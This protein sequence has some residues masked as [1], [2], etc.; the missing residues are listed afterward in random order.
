MNKTILFLKTMLVRMAGSRSCPIHSVKVWHKHFKSLKMD[1]KYATLD[2]FLNNPGLQHLAREIFLNINSVNSLQACQ[3]I[4]QS[5]KQIFETPL[6]WLKKFVQRGL[7][8]KNQEDWMK[9]I[10]SA[11]NSDK[12]NHL[13]LFFKWTFQTK[14]MVDLPCYTNPIVQ[15][16]FRNQIFQSARDNNLEIVKI[17]APLTDNPNAPVKHGWTPIMQAAYHG[18][19][20]IVKIL[21]PL[22]D[23]P[24]TPDKD[25]KTP[26]HLAVCMEA[27]TRGIQKLSNY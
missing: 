8:K 27:I 14:R 1:N 15:D 10:Q 4:N 16:D 6:F 3:E 19:S 24:N 21:A 22:T 5:S 20:E 7:S 9:V 23:D 11:K 17:L 18:H 12:E 2:N 26:I 13:L 25:G